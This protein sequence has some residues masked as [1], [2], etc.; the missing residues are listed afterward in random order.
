[1]Y[2]ARKYVSLTDYKAIV[3]DVRKANQRIARI[4][5]RYGDNA[6]A[7]NNLYGKLDTKMIHAISPYSGEISIKKNMSNAQLNAVRR[8]TKEFLASETST[9]RGIEN[10]KK[11]VKE[12][13]QKVFNDDKL[14]VSDQEINSLYR[15]V[16][17][18]DLRTTAEL[19]GAST[20][21]RLVIDARNKNMNKKEWNDQLKKYNINELINKNWDEVMEDYLDKGNDLDIKFDVKSA[22]DKIYKDVVKNGKL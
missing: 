2:M 18:K 20:L 10:V 1:M 16:E 12:G 15:I 19:I 4:Q 3:K 17:D 6:W 21:W 8:A 11:K 13:L 22:L 14:D 7:V 9:I 5:K